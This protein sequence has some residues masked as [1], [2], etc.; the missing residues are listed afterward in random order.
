VTD[1]LPRAEWSEGQVI[2][3]AAAL[4]GRSGHPLA[5][6][7]V[8]EAFTRELEIPEV[9]EVTAQAGRG[10][11]AALGDQRAWVG[12]L[13]M[14]WEAGVR[15]E[16]EL[17]RKVESLE[18]QGKSVMLVGLDDEIVGLIAVADALRPET[19]EA[20]AALASLGVRQTVMLSGDNQR[21]ASHIAAQLGINQVRAELMPEEKLQAVEELLRAFPV[22][23]MVGDGVNDAPA[24][25]RATVGIAMGGASNAVAL[26]TADVA[27]MASDLTRL[28]FAVALGRATRRVILQNLFISLWG[29]CWRWLSWRCPRS[30]GLAWWCSSTKAARCW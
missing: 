25:A 9:S 13:A 23:G 17:L 11:E 5:Q 27:L 28:P 20:L 12:N 30:R 7:V 4:E 29:L 18:S 21:V 1:V 6:A 24:L 10:L 19:R 8:R 14:F 26:E 3:I 2:E 16:E 15:L 22:V